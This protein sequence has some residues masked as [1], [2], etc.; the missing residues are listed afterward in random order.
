MRLAGTQAGV[1]Q[2]PEQKVRVTLE[3]PRK[4]NTQQSPKTSFSI[5]QLWDSFHAPK[6]GDRL[7][8][9]QRTIKNYFR[10][11]LKLKLQTLSFKCLS[12]LEQSGTGICN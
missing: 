3:M 2:S 4:L 9:S 6:A 1:L 10:C 12:V 5:S 11:S 7:S 8:L